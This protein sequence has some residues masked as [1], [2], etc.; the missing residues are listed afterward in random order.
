MKRTYPMFSIA[1]FRR[2]W[3]IHQY[4]KNRNQIIEIKFRI[5]DLL[6]LEKVK[7]QPLVVVRLRSLLQRLRIASQVN[8]QL[9]QA[10]KAQAL[11]A[12]RKCYRSGFNQRL[13][14]IRNSLKHITENVE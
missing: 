3:Y 10:N 9:H 12:V 1:Y 11:R 8:E 4:R 14:S 13:R 2:C 7:E 5:D 6:K